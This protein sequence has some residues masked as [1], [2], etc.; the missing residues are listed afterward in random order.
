MYRSKQDSKAYIPRSAPRAAGYTLVELLVVIII[1]GI[2]SAIAFPNFQAMA[3]GNRLTSGT[4]EVVA[5]L[6]MARLEAIRRN[7]RVVVC[8]STDGASCSG[9]ANWGRMIT[10]VDTDRDGVVDVGEQ[11][12]RDTTVP[13]P[14]VVNA[15]SAVTNNRISFRPDGVARAGT[16]A[17]IL[18]GR[19]GVCIVTTKPPLNARNV[20]VSGS[21]ISVAS[22]LTSASCAAPT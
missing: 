4:N 18:N 12:V 9:A 21:R 14:A 17:T 10:F 11:V 13:G 1:I 2:V 20:A 16:S 15:S 5:T 22:P 3:N 6:Q 8:S 19:V 7:T